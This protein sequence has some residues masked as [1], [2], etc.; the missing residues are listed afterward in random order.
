M[1]GISTGGM[2]TLLGLLAAESLRRRRRRLSNRVENGP[3]VLAAL[4]SSFHS[5]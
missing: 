3:F 5:I 2:N 4:L 1:L